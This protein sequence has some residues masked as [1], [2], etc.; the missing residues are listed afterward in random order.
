[1]SWTPSE[2]G[3]P[4]LATPDQSPSRGQ[5]FGLLVDAGFPL[6]GLRGTPHPA[7][8]RSVRLER[9]T[10]AELSEAWPADGARQVRRLGACGGTSVFAH[11]EAGYLIDAPAVG[12]HLVDLDGRRILSAPAPLCPGH[13]QTLL[14][15]HVLPLAAT[16]QGL[17]VLHAS[18]VVIAGE[19]VALTGP[20]GSGKSTLATRLILLGARFFTDG[21]VALE[22]RGDRVV[23]HASLGILQLREQ[24]RN[25]ATDLA[26][27]RLATLIGESEETS[28]ELASDVATL[29]LGSLYV[30]EPAREVVSD[31]IVAGV[32]EARVL[33]SS[34]CDISVPTP[35]RRRRHLDLVAF[36]STRTRVFTAR[37]QR[38]H[39]PEA[40]RAMFEHAACR[41]LA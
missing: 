22:I 38:R 13:W 14:A 32:P 6:T 23:A 11:P 37:V 15:T 5:A 9:V 36:L 26:A 2:H 41:G 10:D 27:Q 12:R 4:G 29:S 31:P 34:A 8:G 24:A 35:E 20:S 1:M 16:L 28:V 33:L 7:R 25:A 21:A 19:V 3:G 40:A 39:E 18:A 30:L 17:V